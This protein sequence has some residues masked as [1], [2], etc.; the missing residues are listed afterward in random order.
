MIVRT[1]PNGIIISNY[2]G[3]PKGKR[4]G[5]GETFRV[6]IEFRWMARREL[7]ILRVYVCIYMYCI[8]MK[9]GKTKNITTEGYNAIKILQQ[10]Y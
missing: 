2:E 7:K 10:V 6:K 9:R 8:P 4:R 1:Y 3:G 5:V